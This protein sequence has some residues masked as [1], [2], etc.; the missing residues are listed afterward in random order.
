MKPKK[1]IEYAHEDCNA[2]TGCSEPYTGFKHCKVGARCWAYNFSKRLA[3]HYGYPEWPDSFRPRFHPEQLEKLY[4][5]K[6][7]K[8]IA[9]C[10]MGD[11]A[12][13][14]VHW[15]TEIFNAIEENPQH[16][17]YFLTKRPKLLNRFGKFPDRC[18]VGVT[19][20]C[21]DDEYRIDELREYVD[22]KYRVISL[23]PLYQ[24]VILR[25][26]SSINWL[27]VGAQT[28]PEFQ[29]K[30]SWVKQIIGRALN[31]NIK[32]FMK[33]NLKLDLPLIQ[34]FPDCMEAE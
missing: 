20:N 2:T 32:V 14:K 3:G 8:R 23:E 16:W 33:N 22:C 12:D 25:N 15:M 1:S 19:V 18:F 34:E 30:K 7:P 31:Y 27:W 29:P 6:T 4:K 9:M 26:L 10:F 21:Q 28:N 5:W 17:Y 24:F 13:A 11:I